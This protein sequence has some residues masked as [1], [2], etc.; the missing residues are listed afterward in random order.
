MESIASFRERIEASERQRKVIAAHP[1]TVEQRRPWR[2]GIACGVGLIALLSLAPFTQ[3]ADFAC[4]AGDVAC[5]I[6]AINTANANG[7]A[8]TITVAAGTYTL[9]AVDNDTGGPNGLPSITSELTLRG[10]GPDRTILERAANAPAFRL[11]QIAA[12]GNLRLK[13]LTVQ[14][15]SIVRGAPGGGLQNLGTLT[16]HDTVVRSN[17]SDGPGAGLQNLGTATLTRCAVISNFNLNVFPEGGAIENEGTMTIHR[18]SFKN[19]STEE[20]VGSVIENR[21]RLL[22]TASALTGAFPP[23]NITNDGVLLMLNS[24]SEGSTVTLGG[25]TT[26]ILNSTIAVLVGSNGVMLNTLLT[27]TC[28]STVTSLGW[29]LIADPTHCTIALQPT[30]LTGDPGLDTFTDDGKPGSGHFPLLPSSQAIDAGN[31]PACPRTDQLG[32]RR[33]GRCDIGATR[34]LDGSDIQ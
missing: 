21:G 11:L 17:F 1:H 26:T 5:L 33:I 2:R 15:G 10:A 14:R 24:T 18:C 30:D 28:S 27:G 23:Q 8:N 12:Q 31:S 7:E 20:F 9:T 19:N 22:L 6:D 34:L 32:Q 29:N 25:G 13:G 16:L 4:G 3:A